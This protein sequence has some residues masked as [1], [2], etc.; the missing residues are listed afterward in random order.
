MTKLKA[1]FIG[2]VP[3][4]GTPDEIYAALES[5]A[6][7]GYSG[8]EGGD[9]L[10]RNGDPAE[11]LARVKAFGMEPLS[12]GLGRGAMDLSI[13]PDVVERAKKVGVKRAATFVG[14]VGNYRFGGRETPPTYDE[15]MKEIEDLNAIAKE[16]A[17]EGIVTSF[18]N[19]DAEFLTFYKGKCAFDYMVENSEYLKFEL[20]CGWALYGHFDPVK[21][22]DKLGDKLCA[23]HI[24][25]FTY[26][27]AVSP[28]RPGAPAVDENLR[29][30][31]MPRFTTPGT[32]LLPLAACLEKSL[33]LGMD[34]AI[35]E[36]DFM[37]HMNQFDT[38]TGAYL[39]MRETGFVE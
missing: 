8:F 35:V 31:S 11:N 30:I 17:K 18:H 28:A 26:G 22:L 10:L 38:L 12:V 15:V 5:Y 4:G 27:N 9:M 3:F 36:Q 14:C 37:Y 7:I 34:Y 20:D 24:K 2:F 25:D 33:E 16:L 1:G 23:V 19:H 6:K 32:G 39:N 29:Q 21:T 13:V